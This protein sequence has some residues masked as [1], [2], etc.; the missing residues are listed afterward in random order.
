MNA[1]HKPLTE[2]S[3]AE[4]VE[5]AQSLQAKAV[6]GTRCGDMTLKVAEKTKALSV[7]G[8]QRTPVTLYAAQWERLL[9]QA[10]GIRAFIQEN[11]STL[12]RKAEQSVNS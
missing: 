3:H 5:Y 10:E 7:Y 8:L 11:N 6:K 9:D 1:M 4:L 2:M 12:A